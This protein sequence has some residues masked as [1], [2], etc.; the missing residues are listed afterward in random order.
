MGILL[1]SILLI[2][3]DNNIIKIMKFI[4]ASCDINK[5]RKYILYYTSKY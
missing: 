4:L 1:F 2:M 5:F 3:I